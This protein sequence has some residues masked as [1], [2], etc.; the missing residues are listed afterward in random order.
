[1]DAWIKDLR[2]ALR[3]LRKSPTLT[4]FALL[5]LALGIGANTAIF[6]VTR[7]VLL[8]P[9]PYPDASSIVRVWADTATARRRRTSGG[10][11]R[12]RGDR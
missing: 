9:L 5:T 11:P 6:S 7:A 1:M 8:A 10:D 4:L 12:R 2:Y 3:T